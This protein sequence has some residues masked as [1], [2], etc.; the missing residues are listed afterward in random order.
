MLC[1]FCGGAQKVTDTCTLSSL[2]RQYL[3]EAVKPIAHID[4]DLRVRKRICKACQKRSVTVE[5]E[6]NEILHLYRIAEKAIGK[7]ELLKVIEERAD[8]KRERRS[9]KR[10]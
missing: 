6:I 8:Y 5:I 10:S 2:N 4:E 1:T 3:I 9:R 7:E